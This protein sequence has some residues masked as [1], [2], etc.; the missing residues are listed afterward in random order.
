MTHFRIPKIKDDRSVELKRQM[1]IDEIDQQIDD[2]R[3]GQIQLE[4]I[5]RVGSAMD[6]SSESI[7]RLVELAE[8]G[9]ERLNKLTQLVERMLNTLG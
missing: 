1:L 3:V 9:N 5:K 8:E 6:S 7:K 2:I 4:T